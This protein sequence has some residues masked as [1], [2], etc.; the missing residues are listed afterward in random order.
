MSRGWGVLI[1][2]LFF[3]LF[4]GIYAKAALL[5]RVLAAV[6][7][8]IITLTD[9]RIAIQFRL[10]DLKDPAADSES[11]ETLKAA[12]SRLI[13]R[14]LLLAEARKFSITP[15]GL[16]EEE[17]SGEI[18]KARDLLPPDTYTATR[19]RFGIS[20][21]DLIRRVREKG[22]EEKFLNFR[23]GFF[24]ILSPDAIRKYY[25]E[26]AADYGERPLEAVRGEIETLLTRRES[27][28]LLEEYLSRL[29]G[30]ATIQVNLP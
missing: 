25:Q 23:I 8:E 24:V 30:Q 5:D 7:G 10:V 17:I 26:H 2:L 28:R 27:V 21:D 20:E 19:K 11:P 29:R 9:V 16:S 12:L 22:A 14:K 3:F 4:Q 18:R 13:D 6:D 15:E 1:G